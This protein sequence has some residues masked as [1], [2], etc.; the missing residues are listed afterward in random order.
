MVEPL[1]QSLEREEEIE[2]V[3][4]GRRTGR[5]HRVSLWF[6]YAPPDIWLR[7]DRDADWV[8]NLER[9]PRCRIA[10]GDRS[11]AARRVA[12]IDEDQALRRVVALWRAKYGAEWVADWYVERGRLPIRVQ[13]VSE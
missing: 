3:T 4:R 5:P 6:A 13:I 2:L 10:F 9:E 12:L 1:A 7:G 8:R 11:A